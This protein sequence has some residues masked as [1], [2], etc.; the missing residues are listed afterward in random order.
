M[1][2]AEKDAAEKAAAEM[3][4]AKKAAAGK[5]AA[6]KAAAKK[7]SDEQAFAEKVAAEIAAAGKANADET[8]LKK[9]AEAEKA[10]EQEEKSSLVKSVH[11]SVFLDG[12]CSEIVDDYNW[13]TESIS[14]DEEITFKNDTDEEE[15]EELE[16]ELEKS[17]IILPVAPSSTRSTR[18]KKINYLEM[19]T[20][21]L[22]PLN[23]HRSGEGSSE[24]PSLEKKKTIQQKKIKGVKKLDLNTTLLETAEDT[25]D[26]IHRRFARCNITEDKKAPS[27]HNIEKSKA[28]SATYTMNAKIG[29]KA[30]V[31]SFTT[32]VAFSEKN[33]LNYK[34]DQVG[35]SDTSV[36][37][38][39]TEAQPKPPILELSKI[40]DVG[41]GENQVIEDKTK[42]PKKN[43]KESLKKSLS[44]NTLKEVS[45]GGQEGLK[46][47][48]MEDQTVAVLEIS[49]HVQHPEDE[50]KDSPKKVIR[51]FKSGKSLSVKRLGKV[52][53]FSA[54]TKRAG[55]TESSDS[56]QKVTKKISLKPKVSS[57]PLDKQNEATTQ[58]NIIPSQTNLPSKSIEN[59][60]VPASGITGKKQ[61]ALVSKKVGEHNKKNPKVKIVK[62]MS[63]EVENKEEA[64]EVQASPKQLTIP[65]KIDMK[66]SIVSNDATKEKI[67]TVNVKGKS[68]NTKEQGNSEAEKPAKALK[69]TV[70]HIK[71]TTTDK[72]PI[73]KKKVS[74]PKKSINKTEKSSSTEGD[75]QKTGKTTKSVKKSQNQKKKI[76]S[77]KSLGK[78]SDNPASKAMVDKETENPG[79]PIKKSIDQTK[80][81]TPEVALSKKSN[82][83]KGKAKEASAESLT[84]TDGASTNTAKPSGG[85]KAKVKASKTVEG[86]DEE[87][88]K[89]KDSKAQSQKTNLKQEQKGVKRKHD[90]DT[91]EPSPEKKPNLKKSK[92][93]VPKKRTRANAPSTR[94]IN[95][96][97][98]E[99]TNIVKT[100]TKKKQPVKPASDELAESSNIQKE[101][102]TATKS[103]EGK[104]L[105]KRPANS[106]E[107]MEAKRVK[108][109]D[110]ISF[111][112][113]NTTKLKETVS[114]GQSKAKGSAAGPSDSGSPV[115][116]LLQGVGRKLGLVKK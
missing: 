38:S 76:S 116:K 85:T 16:L 29:K 82:Q 24:K 41:Q 10:G 63:N 2:S 61:V 106:I 110:E 22:S 89:T 26:A 40:S 112:I 34:S 84:T 65:K 75:D 92:L 100:T 60:A 45:T 102:I 66:E 44:L 80:K 8:A 62:N 108:V 104:S 59:I 43:K 20:G 93:T 54:R 107:T 50:D 78:S 5:A 103:K 51:K 48:V 13:I 4:A 98:V 28:N 111:V 47:I 99:S 113:P 33:N 73:K 67:S 58:K 46:D 81:S 15:R 32:S 53:I 64:I 18:G 12:Q 72:A 83:V 9:A 6:E 19:H 96:T 21:K 3:A 14:D 35:I 95:T 94:S 88:T 68:S 74:I 71:K 69:K 27:T 70:D 42:T 49:T 97:G 23:M 101:K 114:K 77:K 79:K 39:S 57:V 1:A 91:E 86:K 7:A 36:E 109:D 37:I 105:G 56:L 87:K 52:K 11:I 25:T 55:R 30:L 90:E 31:K 17:K 115:M